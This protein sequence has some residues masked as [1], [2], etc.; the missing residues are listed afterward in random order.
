MR[1]KSRGKSIWRSFFLALGGY[2]TCSLLMHKHFLGFSVQASLL[3]LP[4]SYQGLNPIPTRSLPRHKEENVN[5]D[6]GKG[7]S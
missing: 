5:Q 3:Y 1:G 2:V 6:Q 4:G 7:E